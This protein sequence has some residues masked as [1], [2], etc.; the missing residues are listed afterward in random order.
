M[1][2]PLAKTIAVEVVAPEPQKT[3]ALGKVA[4]RKLATAPSS[5]AGTWD[6]ARL[7]LD[8]AKA[9]QEGVLYC[10]VMVGFELLALREGHPET[11]GRKPAGG[12]K[13]HVETF[14]TA[15]ERETN[16]SR[17]TIYR[18]L[19]MAEGAAK[20]LK[21]S[22]GVLLK[23]FDPTNQPIALLSG[24]KRDAL[25]GAV[26]KLTDGLTQQEF[27]FDLGLAKVPQGWGATGGA[28]DRK[29]KA[30][31]TEAEERE[32]AV[33][34]AREHWRHDRLSLF[35]FRAEFM[36]LDDTEVRAQID[37]LE[38]LLKARKQWLA[39]PFPDRKAAEI[40]KLLPHA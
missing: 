11:R 2:D 38:A 27:L 17:P 28:R 13:S 5:V 37:F 26:K 29:A 6:G 33:A 32:A 15:A 36:L 3:K 25:S 16:L 12:K 18:L 9:M 23:D 19:A 1:S 21:A 35:T 31:L 39:K 20:R 34:D 14:F 10:Q 7:W 4:A 8:R 24:A 30:N 22:G 40:E